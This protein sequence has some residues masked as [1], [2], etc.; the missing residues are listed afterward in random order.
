MVLPARPILT[1]L[2]SSV[3]RSRMRQRCA[4]TVGQRVH[5]DGNPHP[6]DSWWRLIIPATEWIFWSGKRW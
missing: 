2:Q 4:A 1:R 6:S 5:A 3:G